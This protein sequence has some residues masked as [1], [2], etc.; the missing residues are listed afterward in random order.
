MT[1]NFML[2]CVF[3]KYGSVIYGLKN[4]IRFDH[5]Y[6]KYIKGQAHL[7]KIHAKQIEF[8]GRFLVLLNIR[9]EKIM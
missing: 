6:L 5:E 7:N 2:K 1:K 9:K 8:M 3:C 4:V